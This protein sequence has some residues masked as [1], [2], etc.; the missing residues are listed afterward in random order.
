[1]SYRRAPGG[2]AIALLTAITL[3]ASARVVPPAAAQEVGSSCAD[4]A[5]QSRP[6]DDGR[7][8]LF[9]EFV[10]PFVETAGARRAALRLKDAAFF[11]HRVDAA[12]NA[13][14]LN[15]AMLGFSEEHGE[16]YDDAGVSVTILS[17]NLNTWDLASISLSRDVRVPEL[18][19]PALA[20]PRYPATLRSAYHARGFEGIRAIL[21]D[22]T[23]LSIDFQLLLKDVFL[24]NYMRDVSGAIEVVVPKDYS[25]LGYRL[26]GVE[27]AEDVIP[28]GR[29]TLDAD[30]AMTFVMGEEVDPSTKLDERLYRKNMLLKALS[31]QVHDRIAARDSG[32]VLN[33]VRFSLGELGAKNLTT[34]FDFQL[35]ARGLGKLGQTFILSR[36]DAD[37]SFPQIGAA[38]Q[39]LITDPALGDGGVRRVHRIRDYA[40]EPGPPDHPRVMQEIAMGSLADYMLIAVGG[41]PYS[42]DLVDDYWW[43]VRG[44]VA[45]FVTR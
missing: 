30:R 29:Q 8:I 12:L 1:V 33:L 45:D 24:R 6:V 16:S 34:D 25:T 27:H 15:F 11:D 22:I 20:P 37:A 10:Q 5:A 41:N 9:D 18:E 40:D 7:P 38:R 35:I 19:E 43:F 23:G 2:L 21:E 42:P 26:D 32:F 4:T 3:F 36:A 28:A 17:L 31:C 39:L 13:N 14:R 44:T